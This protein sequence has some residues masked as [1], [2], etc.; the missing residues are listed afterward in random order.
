M[1]PLIPRLVS[2]LRAKGMPEAKAHAVAI[3]TLRRAGD[4]KQ[5]STELTAKGTKRQKMGAA[6]RAKDRA[7]HAST[8]H[9]ARDYSYNAS[10][11]RATLRRSK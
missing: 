3:G 1:T 11:N 4:V 10:T 9:T 6:G 7:A 5:G 2:Q 8:G